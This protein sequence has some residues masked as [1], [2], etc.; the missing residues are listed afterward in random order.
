[1]PPSSWVSSTS[2]IAYASPRQLNL[3]LPPK[4]GQPSTSE[5]RPKSWNH[6]MA[7][8]G[9][10]FMIIEFQLP[11][12]RQGSLWLGRVAQSPVQPG[13]LLYRQRAIHKIMV[14]MGWWLDLM[15]SEVSSKLNDPVILGFIAPCFISSSCMVIFKLVSSR[16]GDAYPM[17]A[18]EAMDPTLGFSPHHAS[19]FPVLSFFSTPSHYFS[20][21]WILGAW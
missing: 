13:L 18:P 16:K 4:P 10:P 15:I 12:Y 3:S 5:S 11:Y 19:F 21:Q 6:R 7:W 20:A 17:T 1:M 2:A 14:G 8:F 9:R